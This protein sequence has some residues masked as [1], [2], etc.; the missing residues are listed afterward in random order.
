MAMDVAIAMYTN[1]QG[2]KP[3]SE[4]RINLEAFDFLWINF[5]K[6][7]FNFPTNNTADSFVDR[8]G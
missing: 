6:I 4:P 1:P 3:L 7:C 5:P 8:V 2:S